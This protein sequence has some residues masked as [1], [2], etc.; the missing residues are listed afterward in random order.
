MA[1]LTAE[2]AN[3]L[4]NN[5]LSVGTEVIKYRQANAGKL[6]EAETTEL[7]KIHKAILDLADYFFTAS[8][9]LV[10]DDVSDSLKTI[11]ET[12]ADIN[13]TY[14]NLKNVQKAINVAGSVVVLGTAIVKQD[15]AAIGTAIGE[16]VK[17]WRS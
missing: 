8:A 10:M 1:N 5:F 17:A 11:R 4:A 6:S 3:E 2:Q 16:V 15:P 12:T 9:L 7:T 13:K 14:K